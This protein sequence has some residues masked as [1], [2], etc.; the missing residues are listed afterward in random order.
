M[1]V[2]CQSVSI[3]GHRVGWLRRSTATS[4]FTPKREM[5]TQTMDDKREVSPTGDGHLV[6]QFVETLRLCGETGTKLGSSCTRWVDVTYAPYVVPD[7]ASSCMRGLH[8][9]R[10]P[11][12]YPLGDLLIQQAVGANTHKLSERS[13]LTS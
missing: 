4:A 3:G 9:V 11:W 13:R 6:R 7:D 1:E 2:Q 5:I 10:T 12:K 8:K